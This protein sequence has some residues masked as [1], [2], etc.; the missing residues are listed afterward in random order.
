[1]EPHLYLNALMDAAS[2]GDAR[3][4]YVSVTILRFPIPAVRLLAYAN[5]FTAQHVVAWADFMASNVPSGV[6][7]A[8]V[9]KVRK[10]CLDAVIP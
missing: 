8:A 10:L 1:M 2:A 7:V 9:D 5:G 6:L 4:P 3:K